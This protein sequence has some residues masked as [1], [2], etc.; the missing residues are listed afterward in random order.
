LVVTRR[1]AQLLAALLACLLGS[2]HAGAADQAP[3]V[4]WHAYRGPE[5]V[6][7]ERVLATW[8]G[9]AVETL[10]IPYDAYAAKLAAAIKLGQGPDLFIDAHERLGDYRRRKLV[11][12]VGDAM[13]D[14]TIFVPAAISAVAIDG[15]YYGVP[16]SQKCVVLFLNPALVTGPPESFESMREKLRRPLAAGQFLLAY[17]NGNAYAHAALLH[18][19]G[20]SYL[21]EADQFG[22]IGAAAE[23]SLHLAR[24]LVV[25][26][27][28][29]QRA[30]GALVTR[31]FRSGKAGYAISG[32]WLAAELSEAKVPYQVAVL[33]RLAATGV[34]LRP[35]LT[36]EAVMLS[37]K[38]AARPEVRALARR[39]AGRDAARLRQQL[40]RADSARR[41]VPPPA[42][43]DVLTTFR[44]QAAQAVVMPSR[45][46]M[47]AVW[48]PARRALQ[49]AISARAKPGEALREARRRFEDVRRPPPPPTSPTPW[50][51]AI[52]VLLLLASYRL[53]QRA[54]HPGFRQAVRRSLPAYAYLIHAVVAVGVLVVLPL[55]AGALI[56]LYAGQPGEMHFVGLAHFVN[57]ITA[58]GGDLLASGSFYIV[59]LVTLLWTALNLGFHLLIGMTLGMLLARSALR[60][61]AIYR[62]LLIIPWAVPSYVTA[63]AWK[64]MFHRQFGAVTGLIQALNRAF[65][66]DIEA[67]DWF[68]RFSTGLTAN[69]ATNVWLGFPFIM[70]VTM[71]ALTTVPREVL[72][73]ASVDGAT[74]WQR[75]VRVTL[76]M[77]RPTMLP[78]VLL[79]AVWTFNMFNVVFL[80]SGGAPDGQTD[81]LVSEAYRWAFTRGAQYGYAAAY[82]VL[83]F[84][85]LAGGTFL[86]SRYKR[87]PVLVGEVS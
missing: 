79:G 50:I 63:L 80:V 18:A 65:G 14:P 75:L 7:L 36:I 6:A 44:Q 11:A 68:A 24:D 19:L 41:D 59:L 32:P 25:R 51:L 78:A 60:G 12:P 53:L 45:V 13:V 15:T 67:I 23:A 70:V 82:A 77:I 40:A 20:G 47:R 61:R 4:L 5:K 71:S 73:A 38:G 2:P 85:L 81:I 1:A 27:D 76:P 83:I 46:A 22:F 52:G 48:E 31:L 42:D 39:L 69:V 54:R 57:I 74:R 33:P 86:A 3:I 9:Q 56:A 84:V 34:P 10:A 26:G 35:F 62:V 87:T 49:Q 64:G 30:D 72:D 21:G 43:D 16:L 55:L 28:V 66:T 8:R 29:P 17:E 58:R 37:A